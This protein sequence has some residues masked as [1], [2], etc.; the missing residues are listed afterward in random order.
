ME[1]LFYLFI[2]TQSFDHK[3]DFR[4]ENDAIRRDAL[5]ALSHISEHAEGRMQIFRSGGIPE[6]VRMLGIPLD[7][8]R[9]YAITTLHNL[10]LFMDYAKEV[11]STALFFLIF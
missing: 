6:L 1:L 2:L 4:L 11:S 7:A 9:H 3:V 10:L 5:G 8:V